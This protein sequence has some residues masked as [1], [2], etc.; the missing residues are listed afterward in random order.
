MVFSTGNNILNVST[1]EKNKKLLLVIDRKFHQ[2]RTVV[3]R[4]LTP[5]SIWIAKLTCETAVRYLAFKRGTESRN[6]SSS[7]E[8]P[9]HK[10]QF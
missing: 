9:R 10:V 5:F 2:G 6:W 4:R 7:T 8:L 3:P 1:M